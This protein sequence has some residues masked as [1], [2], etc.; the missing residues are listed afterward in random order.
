MIVINALACTLITRYLLYAPCVEGTSPPSEGLGEAFFTSTCSLVH[1]LPVMSMK[2][3][4]FEDY[5]PRR[6]GK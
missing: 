4:F 6:E 2:S 3:V 1:L 5:K